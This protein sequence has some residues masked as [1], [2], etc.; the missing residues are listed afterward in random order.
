MRCRHLR[1]RALIAQAGSV[2]VSSRSSGG[3]ALSVLPPHHIVLARREQ[4]LP[5]LPAAFAL[6][7]NKYASDYPS[8]ISFITG[9]SRT[10]DIE[11][12]LVLGAH[13]PG[14]HCAPSDLCAAHGLVSAGIAPHRANTL[15]QTNQKM[16]N[17]ANALLPL[18]IAVLPCRLPAARLPELRRPRRSAGGLLSRGA[19]S[20]GFGETKRGSA[21][22]AKR[23]V[24]RERRSVHGEL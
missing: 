15:R 16:K 8:L 9:P 3:R 6:L 19:I 23:R 10:G 20:P 24:P 22:S 14:A 21:G 13:G 1:M 2:L 18:G 11:R 4:L 17:L 12:I 5:D 7:R